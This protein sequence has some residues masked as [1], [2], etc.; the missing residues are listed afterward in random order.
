MIIQANV[1]RAFGVVMVAIGMYVSFSYASINFDNYASALCVQDENSQLFLNNT[2]KVLGWSFLSITRVLEILPASQWV[3]T[4][5]SGVVIAEQGGT[6]K[7]AMQ[8]M[9]A[10]SDAIL[11]LKA[12]RTLSMGYNEVRQPVVNDE[13]YTNASL[14]YGSRTSKRHY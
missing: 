2:D 11:G 1:Y 4:Y 13:S 3:E 9:V 14:L 12:V 6:R 10:S 7:P 8:F 5:P